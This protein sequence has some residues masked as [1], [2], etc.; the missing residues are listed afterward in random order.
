LHESIDICHKV[1]RSLKAKGKFRG[2][3]AKVVQEILEPVAGSFM[4]AARYAP[5]WG[6]GMNFYIDMWSGAISRTI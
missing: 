1:E 6:G 3:G 5:S 2:A 4:Y